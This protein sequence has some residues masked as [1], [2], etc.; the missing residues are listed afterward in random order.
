MLVLLWPFELYRLLYFESDGFAV[1]DRSGCFVKN[2]LLELVGSAVMLVISYVCTIDMRR[3]FVC[4]L[5]T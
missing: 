4:Y 1:I 3:R 2:T 5:L